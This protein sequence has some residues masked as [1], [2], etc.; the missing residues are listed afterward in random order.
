MQG[1]KVLSLSRANLS[2][3]IIKYPVS[4]VEQAQIGNFFRQ[5]DN[6]ITLHQRERYFVF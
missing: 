1:I 5:L 2:N 3:T 4:E 6:L